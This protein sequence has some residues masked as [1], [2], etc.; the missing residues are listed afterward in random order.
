LSQSKVE[1]VI[2]PGHNIHTGND[3]HPPPEGLVGG[4]FVSGGVSKELSCG[5]K[6]GISLACE[7]K[8]RFLALKDGL[9]MT[10]IER[11]NEALEIDGNG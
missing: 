7:K 9:G 10:A 2:T 5:A 11:R 6:R 1:R 4:F 8:E 3:S